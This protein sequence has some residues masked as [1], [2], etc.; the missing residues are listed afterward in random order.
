MVDDKRS[1]F[2]VKIQRVSDQV[3]EICCED[4]IEATFDSCDQLSQHSITK[5][6]GLSIAQVFDLALALFRMKEELINQRS[7]GCR[8]AC[9]IVVRDHFGCPYLKIRSLWCPNIPKTG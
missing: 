5:R 2:R 1:G 3:I 7:V 4:D 6:R 8:R 9:G